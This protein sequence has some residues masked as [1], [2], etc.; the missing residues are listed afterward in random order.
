MSTKNSN[1][2][3]G[4]RI[5]DVVVQCLNQ[6]RDSLVFKIRNILYIVILKRLNRQINSHEGGINLVV[7]NKII[8]LESSKISCEI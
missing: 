7:Y 8:V 3:I 2:T 5:C 6:P 4:N 1:Y